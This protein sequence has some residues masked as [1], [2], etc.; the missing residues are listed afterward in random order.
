MLYAPCHDHSVTDLQRRWYVEHEMGFVDTVDHYSRL[1]RRMT[2]ARITNAG[3]GKR[4]R[5]LHSYY[6][7]PP[8]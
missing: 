3:S 8:R 5:H 7:H 1:G 4:N 6:P 2:A